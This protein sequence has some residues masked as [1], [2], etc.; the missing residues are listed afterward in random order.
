MRAPRETFTLKTSDKAT[1]VCAGATGE[2]GWATCISF[3]RRC[4]VW[5][6]YR[7]LKK[8]DKNIEEISNINENY[9]KSLD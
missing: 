6:K 3:T 4:R 1:T 8:K 2:G 7:G 9:T 5:R